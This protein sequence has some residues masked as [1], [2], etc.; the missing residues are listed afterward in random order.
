MARLR[1]RERAQEQGMNLSQLHAVVNKRL[2]EPVAMAT[3]RRYW[4]STKD[5]K[6]HGPPIEL[7]DVHLMGTI[8]RAL[9]VSLAELLN[10]DE[11]GNSLLLDAE[12]AFA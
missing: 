12:W 5:G 10:E 4:H 2:D 9:G 7:V 1:V 6:E 11:L 8:A 3:M